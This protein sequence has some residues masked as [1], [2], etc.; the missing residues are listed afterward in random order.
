MS[1]IHTNTGIRIS[2]MPGARMFRMVT[3][4]FT[5]ARIEEA[6]S[7]WRPSIQKSMPMPGEYCRSVRLV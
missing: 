7:T 1:V 6:P 4:K 2:V 3:M 5:P